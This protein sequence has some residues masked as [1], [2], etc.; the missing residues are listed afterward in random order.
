MGGEGAL[1]VFAPKRKGADADEFEMGIFDMDAAEPPGRDE[2]ARIIDNAVREALSA[3]V[4][5]RSYRSYERQMLRLQ[6]AEA[7][8]P[9]QL[10]SRRPTGIFPGRMWRP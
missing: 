9:S 6:M 3:S 8:V 1:H 4:E 7:R 5:G 10:C 2:A